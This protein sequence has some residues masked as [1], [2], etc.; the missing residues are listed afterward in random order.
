MTPAVDL[1][2]LMKNKTFKNINYK[3]TLL[4]SLKVVLFL[5]FLYCWNHWAFLTLL[6][7]KDNTLSIQDYFVTLPFNIGLLAALLPFNRLIMVIAMLPI[8][9]TSFIYTNTLM[10]AS[11]KE[12]A[13]VGILMNLGAIFLF[14]YNRI[15]SKQKVNGVKT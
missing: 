7:S 1:W 11:S 13:W 9:F 5:G 3:K 15:V 12:D 8:V 14:W 2:K 10:F 4:F 6:F